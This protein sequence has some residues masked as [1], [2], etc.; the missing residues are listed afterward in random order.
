MKTT[1]V[2]ILEK[3][4]QNKQKISLIDNFKNNPEI[5][6]DIELFD[7]II[8]LSQLQDIFQFEL[9]KF[10]N[11][12]LDRNEDNLIKY[13]QDNHHYPIYLRKYS[14]E[15]LRSL[16]DNRKSVEKY[17]LPFDFY[18]D[19]DDF[20]KN[21]L[22]NHLDDIQDYFIKNQ[23]NLIQNKLILEIKNEAL[24]EQID[25]FSNHAQEII[26]WNH[27]EREQSYKQ[28]TWD[29]I[30]SNLQEEAY[31]PFIKT[32]PKE[33]FNI[34]KLC[35]Q[36]HHLVIREMIDRHFLEKKDFHDAA[37]LFN[38][39]FK[40]IQ[41]HNYINRYTSL[42]KLFPDINSQEILTSWKF[43]R[44]KAF[45][46]I[47]SNPR[48]YSL[49][50]ITHWY[51]QLKKENIELLIK[52]ENL[53]DFLL[54]GVQ[55][56][57]MNKNNKIKK[58]EDQK[59]IDSILS[60]ENFSLAIEHNNIKF[61]EWFLEKSKKYSKEIYFRIDDHILSLPQLTIEID[62]K[63]SLL[64]EMEESSIKPFNL[65]KALKFSN[66]KSLLLI[67]KIFGQNKYKYFDTF[68]KLTDE[69]QEKM[70][71]ET[72]QKNPASINDFFDSH[73]SI[74][75]EKTILNALFVHHT[76]QFC[77]FFK[78]EGNIS[79]SSDSLE[80]Y[81]NLSSM[82]SFK[83]IHHILPNHFNVL[84]NEQY[85]LRK[86]FTIKDELGIKSR[87]V[88]IDNYEIFVQMNINEQKK[89]KIKL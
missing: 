34:E 75:Y 58:I 48:N 84:K 47:E 87:E 88:S 35:Y 33:F 55:I 70:F 2:K 1:E 4:H 22:I 8:D 36:N 27:F 56:Y 57:K 5:F 21:F 67:E 18:K 15:Y 76:K 39:H 60:P 79:F 12:F 65:G 14:N 86:I 25:S 52:D 69:E 63:F 82:I 3:I 6:N 17:D 83:N 66:Q 77:D 32:I 78:I 40:L 13:N 74:S 28:P 89:K 45:D 10:W 44:K 9:L 53:F 64:K 85:F 72:V 29:N 71:L 16:I 59:I 38:E 31:F 73:Y 50:Y 80:D 19:Y 26:S 81:E 51:N 43:L 68:I 30:I 62:Q 37:F 42:K 49:F 23:K 7:S 61:V 54:D 11:D 41:P 46:L 20:K 24:I